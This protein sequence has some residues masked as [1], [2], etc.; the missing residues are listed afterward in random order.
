MKPIKRRGRP[1]KPD[2]ER[3]DHRVGASLNPGEFR[4]LA[5]DAKRLEMPMGALLA[6]TWREWRER[7]GR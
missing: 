2:W 7:N 5:A 1:P 3:C 6:H 4:K